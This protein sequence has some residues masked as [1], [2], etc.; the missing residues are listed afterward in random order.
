MPWL[1][2]VLEGA[3]RRLVSAR[4]SCFKTK[5]TRLVG[6]SCGTG[7]TVFHEYP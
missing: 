1:S 4:E 2:S 7:L 6:S 3:Q 5:F